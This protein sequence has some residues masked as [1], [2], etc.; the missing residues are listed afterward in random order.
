MADPR[1]PRI[2]SQQPVP[3]ADEQNFLARFRRVLPENDRRLNP[4][5]D[6]QLYVVAYELPQGAIRLATVLV[7]PGQTLEDA[8]ALQFNN[9]VVKKR[10]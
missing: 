7:G 1:K 9:P 10:D 5:T 8:C 4:Q 6:E 3:K 2:V